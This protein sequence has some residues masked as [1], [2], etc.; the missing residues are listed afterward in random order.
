MNPY[1]KSTFHVN[2]DYD[3]EEKIWKWGSDDEVDDI[4]WARDD[5]WFYPVDRVSKI[6]FR[7]DVLLQC[8]TTLFL[9]EDLIQV[10][11]EICG[12][13]SVI[14]WKLVRLCMMITVQSLLINTIKFI[15]LFLA[16]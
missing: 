15:L 16:E 12:E 3:F 7:K 8:L 5:I 13:E 11:V 10:E 6:F 2:V 9:Q 14:S 1:H 4:L